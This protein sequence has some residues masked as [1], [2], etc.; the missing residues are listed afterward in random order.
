LTTVLIIVTPRASGF[1]AACQLPLVLALGATAVTA[2]ENALLA[3]RAMVTK[4][5]LPATLIVRNEMP[6]CTTVVM[7]P[8]DDPIRLD[9]GRAEPSPKTA[10]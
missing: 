8:I 9:R 1:V 5:N 10:I 6:G 3:V 7:Q 2:A 4:A